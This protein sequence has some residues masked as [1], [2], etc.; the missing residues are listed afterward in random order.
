[1]AMQCKARRLGVGLVLA[2]LVGAHPARA[3]TVE[4]Y[5]LDALGSVRAITNQ[6]AALVVRHDYLPFGEE[7]TPP[8]STDRRMFTGKERDS[9]TGFDYFGARYLAAKLGRFTTVDP[10]MTLPENL[11]DPQRWNR[12]A[13]VRNNPL[14]YTDP[15]GREIFSPFQAARPSDFAGVASFLSGVAKSVANVVIALNSP[16]DNVRPEVEAGRYFQPANTAESVGMAVGDFGL[17]VAPLAARTGGLSATSAGPKVGSAG[18]PGAFKRFSEATKSAA[19]AESPTCVFCGRPTNSTR[20]PTQSN[21][22][23]AIPK[24]RGGNNSLANAQ[25]T[26]RDC[27]LAKG[28]LTTKEFVNIR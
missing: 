2:L 23:H 13:Y 4:Y 19:R 12:Y 25:N 21:I 22:D 3:Q 1:M 7:W 14:R 17:L 6:S 9:E 24:S 18:G 20:G 28:V 8:A 11:A 27:N 16:G 26:C 10:L 15:D 5:H